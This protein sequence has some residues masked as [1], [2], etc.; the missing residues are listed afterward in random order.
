[1]VNINAPKPTPNPNKTVPR[2]ISTQSM[3]V[4][5]PEWRIAYSQLTVDLIRGMGQ[6]ED[7][8]KYRCRDINGP[9]NDVRAKTNART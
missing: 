9:Q 3:W 4:I 5:D 1:M 6:R 2:S 7:N 8:C